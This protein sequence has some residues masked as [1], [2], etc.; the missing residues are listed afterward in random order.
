MNNT[1][2][3]IQ[4]L[5][6]RLNEFFIILDQNKKYTSDDINYL[7]YDIFENITRIELEVKKLEQTKK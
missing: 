4:A 7:Y 3:L 5:K 2:Y 6:V 1:I